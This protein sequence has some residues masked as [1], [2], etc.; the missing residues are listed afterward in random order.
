MAVKDFSIFCWGSLKYQCELWKRLLMAEEDVEAR[1]EKQVAKGLEEI[2]NERVINAENHI[3]YMRN[4][5]ANLTFT[6]TVAFLIAGLIGY[7]KGTAT[8]EWPEF[9]VLAELCHQ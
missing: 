9:P 1:L 8:H 2:R 6:I 4:W 5:L 3:A 7:R